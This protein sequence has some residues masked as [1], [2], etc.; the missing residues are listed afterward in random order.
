[1]I[2]SFPGKSGET[3][4]QVSWLHMALVALWLTAVVTLIVL[5]I[6]K[7]KRH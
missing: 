2:I 5:F 7:N 3:Y 6:V 1:M 4:V